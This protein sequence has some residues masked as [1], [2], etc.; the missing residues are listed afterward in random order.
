MTTKKQLSANQKNALKGG[1]KTEQGKEISKMNSLKHGFF[2]KITTDYD[3]IDNQDFCESF[4]K[5]FAPANIYEEQLVEMLLSNLLTLRRICLVEKEYIETKL[6][7]D[8]GM[9]FDFSVKKGY[10]PVIKLDLLDDLSKFQ[11]YKTSIQRCIF[12]V[13]HELERL[14]FNR[15]SDFKYIPNAIDVSVSADN[16]F[17]LGD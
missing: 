3:K 16:G 5:H 2:S 7:P 15:N 4:Y 17:V 9:E 1:V 14:T 12:K 11:K 8:I 13:Q 10:K 6:H